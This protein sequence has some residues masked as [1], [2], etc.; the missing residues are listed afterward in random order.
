MMN[1]LSSTSATQL[2]V[3]HWNESPLYLSEQERY[4]RYPWLYEVAEFRYH[5]GQRVLEVG[6][7]SGCDIL[8]F[9]KYGAKAYGIDVTPAHVVLA[10]QRLM[11]LAH[12]IYADGTRIP[13]ASESFDY[14]YS[15]GVLHHLDKPREMVQE[16]LRVLR[17]GGRF[18]VLV[19]NRWSHVPLILM[20]KH[21][22]K[23]RLWIE[24]STAPVH[25]E[26]YTLRKLRAI[27]API[28]LTIKKYECY[29]NQKLG[30][31]IGWFLGAKG[32]KPV[33]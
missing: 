1:V 14:V 10:R 30:Q 4:S 15:C 6:C 19:Y 5:Q 17:P 20:L 32:S 21:G 27:F 28:R 25:I 23:W 12:I 2:A 7:G 13:F 18:N 26:L 8:Q 11:G 16:I 29:H 33:S 22:L 31:F 24:N 3:A 9:A